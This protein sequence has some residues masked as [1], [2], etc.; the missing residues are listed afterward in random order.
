VLTP[1][2]LVRLRHV[3]REVAIVPEVMRYAMR[4]VLATH[5]DLPGGCATAKSYLRYGASPRGA[6]TL[7][8]GGRVQALLN[9]RQHVGIADIRAVAVPALRHRIGRSFEAEADG[10][11]ADAL[12]E[13]VLAEVPETEGRVAQEL[14]A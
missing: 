10:L 5:P 11:S 3:V 14:R 13:R 6:Q 8:L 2:E 1:D 7:V 12:V 9:G 4:L